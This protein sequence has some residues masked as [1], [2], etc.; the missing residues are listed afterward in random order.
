MRP[1]VGGGANDMELAS[2]MGFGAA[3]RN[4]G[5]RIAGRDACPPE[6]EE[7]PLSG[8]SR[9]AAGR[10]A[11]RVD[12]ADFFGGLGI[13]TIGTMELDDPLSIASADGDCDTDFL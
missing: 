3:P 10:L 1:A 11:N 7:P 6:R 9:I 8:T 2:T 4:G 13:V 12:S 5:R